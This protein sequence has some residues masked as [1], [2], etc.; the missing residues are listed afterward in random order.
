MIDEQIKE[1]TSSKLIKRARDLN[2][3]KQAYKLSLKIHAASLQFPKIE[4]YAL[5]D[6]LRRASKSI[7]ANIAEG[8]VR[9]RYSAPEFSRFLLI[10]EASAEEVCVWL[11]YSIDLGYISKEQFQE[12]DNSYMSIQAMLAKF[13][14]NL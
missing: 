7:C 6:Q 9:Q 12:W 4:Q 13:R 1:I 2:V 5:A 11:E 8:F 14:K 3:S 10:A